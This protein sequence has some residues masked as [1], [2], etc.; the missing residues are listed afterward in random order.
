VW[1]RSLWAG[2]GYDVLPENNCSK[3]RIAVRLVAAA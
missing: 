3:F 2:M 1:V